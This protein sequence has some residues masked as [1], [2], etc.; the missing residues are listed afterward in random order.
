MPSSFVVICPRGELNVSLYVLNSFNIHED[1]KPTALT[2]PFVNVDLR[3]AI[4]NGVAEFG[5]LFNNIFDKMSRQQLRPKKIM[6]LLRGI[7][8]T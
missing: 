2:C 1:N 6:M 3:L 7:E 4:L 5:H 8:V